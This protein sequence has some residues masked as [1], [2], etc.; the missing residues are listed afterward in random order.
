MLPKAPKKS[1]VWLGTIAHFCFKANAVFHVHHTASFSNDRFAGVQFYL[2]KL[3]VVA[4]YLV[5][6][7]MTFFSFRML[8]FAFHFYLGIFSTQ[9][10][11]PRCK[12]IIP[13][14]INN[15]VLNQLHLVMDRLGQLHSAA[16]PEPSGA[17][18]SVSATCPVRW[19]LSKTLSSW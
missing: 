13:C 3:Q 2:H 9:R 6:Y 16:W 11:S 4:K 14:P 7:F 19:G 17:A 10:P 8:L 1:L 18:F 15:R 12:H 5:I